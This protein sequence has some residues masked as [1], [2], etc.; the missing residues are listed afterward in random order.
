MSQRP[1]PPRGMR[2]LLPSEVA[3]RRHL[4]TKILDVYERYGFEQIE[5]PLVE[6]IERLSGSDGGENTTLIYKVLKRGLDWPPESER[7][8]VDLGLR[9]DLTVPLARFYSTHSNELL[10]PFK[11]IQT[12]P[13]FRAERPQKGRYR[14]FTQ[15]DIDIIGD[16][17]PDAEIEL[18]T[19][20]VEA[21]NACGLGGFSIRMNHRRI[22]ETWVNGAGFAPSQRTSVLIAMDKLDKI[23][24]DG[25]RSELQTF[26]NV[27]AADRLIDTLESVATMPDW[28]DRVSEVFPEGTDKNAFDDLRAMEAAVRQVSDVDVKL[29][30]SLVRGM[31]Y[32]TGAIFEVQHEESSGSVGGGGRYD[33]MVGSMSGQDTPAV[34]FSI[35]FERL[36]HILEGAA[37]KRPGRRIVLLH[38]PGES[39]NAIALTTA[40]LRANGSIVRREQAVKNRGAQLNRLAQAGYTHWAELKDGNMSDLQ[41]LKD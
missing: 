5:T 30:P 1:N 33:G 17:S 29:D 23:G 2:D 32:Y 40:Q 6:E 35:G 16:P 36:C 26:G 19:A 13:V 15:C 22:L 34:G 39:S 14:Q 41:E 7:D 25:V 8:A 37:T 10:L 31:G 3:L 38:G 27:D 28:I 18:V 4:L 21:L 24:L 20:T 12:G 9:Y 11:S